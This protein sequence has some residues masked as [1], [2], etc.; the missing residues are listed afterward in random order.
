[1]RAAFDRG[2]V[3]GR[4]DADEA[5]HQALHELA[6]NAYLASALARLREQVHR[7][8]YLTAQAFSDSPTSLEEHEATFEAV[9][10]GDPERAREITQDH[11]AR[12][13]D[14]TLRLVP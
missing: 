4:V 14:A 9:A 6:D 1:M 11:W 8:R 2:D 7:V 12:V 5:F 10:V 13:R 3:A